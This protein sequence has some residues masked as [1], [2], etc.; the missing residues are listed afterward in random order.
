[1]KKGDIW[2][3]PYIKAM[4]EYYLKQKA[5]SPRSRYRVLDEEE[6]QLY[7]G[8]A[9]FFSPSRKF[10]FYNSDTDEQIYQIK[11]KL[12]SLRRAYRLYDKKE[13]LVA[14]AK[15]IR[16][17]FKK[18]IGIETDFGDFVIEGNYWAHDF[19]ILEGETVV[20]SINKKLLSFGDSYHITINDEDNHEFYL[21]LLIMI[22]SKFHQKK[23][24]SNR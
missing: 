21:A 10:D 15:T 20:A 4:K 3:T 12:F 9:R 14:K 6:N 19:T 17:F 16:S 8:K 5:F 13:A 24:R 22:D 1:M 7:H 18:R 23:K 11:R 2:Q